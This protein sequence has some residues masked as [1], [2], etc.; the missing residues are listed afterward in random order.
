MSLTTNQIVFLLII[1]IGLWVLYPYFEGFDIT[2]TEFVPV[3]APRHGL[4]GDLLKQHWIGQD[5]RS[6]YR[7]VLLSDS[8]GEMWESDY[9]PAQ[10]GIQ[11]CGTVPCPVN[12]YD[13]MDTCYKCK[14]SPPVPQS[15]SIWPHVKN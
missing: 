14:S 3:G 15:Y 8:N 7:Q 9:S 13:K 12:G 1:I 10:Q 5:F 6:D 11:G 2:T 4:R